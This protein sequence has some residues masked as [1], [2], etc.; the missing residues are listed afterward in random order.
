MNLSYLL[1]YKFDEIPRLNRSMNE[2]DGWKLFCSS[3][4]KNFSLFLDNQQ[5]IDHQTLIFGLRELTLSESNEFCSNETLLI[6]INPVHFT[7]DYQMRIYT[8]GCYSLDKENQWKSE[9]L[10]VGSK[11]NLYETE[12]FSTHLTKFASGFVILPELIDWNYVFN[13]GEFHK[14]KTIYLTV[15]IVTLMY[16]I[17]MI[18]AR[19][20]DKKDFEKLGVTPL[21][22]NRSSD[23]YFYQLIVFTGQRKDSGTKSKVHFVLYGD[24]EVTRIR[25]FN[26]SQREMFQRDGIDSF[27]MRVPKSLGLLN[28]LHIWHDN[29]GKDSFCIIGV[30]LARRS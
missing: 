16:I 18:Y 12:C 19:K 6:P 10:I 3:I 25:T 30:K 13:N 9:G 11:T 15:I 14:N 22:D 2:I 27:I 23:N 26:S 17:L 1:I 29:S 7:S 21:S 28:C 8:S 4:Q 20:Y 24:K 5:T